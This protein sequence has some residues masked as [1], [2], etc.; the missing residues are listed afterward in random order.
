MQ[1]EVLK[2]ELFV[3]VAVQLAES[4]ALTTVVLSRHCGS[5]HVLP[6]AT[7]VQFSSSVNKLTV[8]LL[9]S[10]HRP[11]A[12]VSVPALHGTH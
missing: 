7:V 1:N 9:L 3:G 10:T 8:L 6:F 4:F 12:G 11:V 5:T 2:K